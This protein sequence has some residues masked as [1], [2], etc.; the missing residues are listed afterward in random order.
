MGLCRNVEVCLLST[1]FLLWRE[2]TGHSKVEHPSYSHPISP[3]SNLISVSNTSRQRKKGRMRTERKREGKRKIWVTQRHQY[4]LRKS[5]CHFL[6]WFLSGHAMVRSHWAS[7]ANKM[8]IR[9][10]TPTKIGTQMFHL[11]KSNFYL[12]WACRF[13][14]KSLQRHF[15][16]KHS[17]LDIN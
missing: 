10:E 11:I 14:Q 3:Y 12:T 6:G 2:K 16:L 4:C 7:A 9:H 5:Q 13:I 17:K 1:V 8:G 15:P